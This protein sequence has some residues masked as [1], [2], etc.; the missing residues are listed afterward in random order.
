MVKEDK[1]VLATSGQL[2]AAKIYEPISHVKYWVTD[3]IAIAVSRSYSWLLHRAQVPSPLR[4]W[5]PYRPT[6]LGKG[7]VVRA[8][9]I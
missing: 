4:T 7:C 9:C 5:D 6:V 2:M 1:V 3:L 8:N